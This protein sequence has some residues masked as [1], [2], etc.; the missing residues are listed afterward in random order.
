VSA[1][2]WSLSDYREPRIGRRRAVEP[3]LRKAQAWVA[4]SELAMSRRFAVMTPGPGV[5]L[6]AFDG[7]WLICHPAV[8]TEGALDDS[9]AV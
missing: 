6:P 3:M 2:D 8:P 7:W 1:P 4:R 5:G 9:S